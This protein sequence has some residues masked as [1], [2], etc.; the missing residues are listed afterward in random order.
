VR[1][2][3]LVTAQRCGCSSDPI[4]WMHLEPAVKKE[5]FRAPPR[6]HLPE[7]WEVA[8]STSPPIA[9]PTDA[10]PPPILEQPAA[11]IQ[12]P[13]PEPPAAGPAPTVVTESF[14]VEIVESVVEV[15]APNPVVSTP[16]AFGAG[17]EDP[18]RNPA[19]T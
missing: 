4:Q 9:P 8:E 11:E 12:T 10:E 7:A 17:V 18:P 16:D 3:G 19:G 14:T 1:T 13:T 6:E 15:S 2:P 5:P